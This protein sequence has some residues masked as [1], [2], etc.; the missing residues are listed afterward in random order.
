V[1]ARYVEFGVDYASVDGN[2]EPSW[3]AVK[4]AQADFVSLRVAEGT[5]IDGTHAK[6]ASDA[7]AAG[8]AV[9]GYLILNWRQMKTADGAAQAAAFVAAHGPWVPGDLPPC[10][11]LEFS[12]DLNYLASVEG[13]DQVREASNAVRAV[14]AAFGACMVYTSQQQWYENFD[15]SSMFPSAWALWLATPYSW[16]AGNPPHIFDDPRLGK[17]GVV[18]QPWRA[19]PGPGVRAQQFQGDARGFAGIHQ[20]DLDLW[21]QLELGDHGPDVAWLQVK[22]GGL[23]ADGDYGPKT[24]AAVRSWQAA[25]GLAQTGSVGVREFA[26][27]A[28]P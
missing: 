16:K 15:D 6:H 17:L 11:D 26:R 22:L 28:H 20:C 1:T 5:A 24:Q 27:L 12:G 18:P 2:P 7:R 23:A 9:Q 13:W 14:V 10:V 21:I 4:A 3:P 8:L 19:A 25:Q